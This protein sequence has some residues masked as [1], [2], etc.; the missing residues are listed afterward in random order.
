MFYDLRVTWHIGKYISNN[1]IA[2][3]AVETDSFYRH[4][5]I[6][7]IA[8]PPKHTAAIIV[9][10]L[11]NNKF[12]R[13]EDLTALGLRRISQVVTTSDLFRDT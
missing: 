10:E 1:E 6:G 13:K 2:K 5:A 9:N 8:T 4:S 7:K 12:M 11:I 3:N